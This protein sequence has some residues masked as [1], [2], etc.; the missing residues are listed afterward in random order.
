MIVCDYGLPL[1]N[2]IHVWYQFHQQHGITRC[3]LLENLN[4]VWLLDRYRIYL[5][6]WVYLIIRF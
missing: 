5:V 1:L 6:F 4:Y 3:L 2:Q